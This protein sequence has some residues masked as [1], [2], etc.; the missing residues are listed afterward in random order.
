M[1]L[2]RV[3]LIGC[4]AVGASGLYAQFPGMPRFP[5]GGDSR[6]RRQRQQRQDDVAPPGVPVPADSP[7][8]EAFRRLE[9]QSVYHQRMTF[10]TNDP[11]IT[12]MMAQM[13]FTPAET[14]TAGDTKQV[15][16]HF[17][18]PALGQVEDFELRGVLRNGRLAKKWISPG[19]GRI[20]KEQDAQIA[21][22]LAEQEV[23]SAS[24][25]ARNLAMG[26]MGWAGAGL[27][28]RVGVSDARAGVGM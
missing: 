23:Q 26:P 25:I 7:I 12:Q 9:Q 6:S 16:M 4:L 14:I 27:P 18:M 15:S 28:V 5:G 11:Q 1:R 8:F 19:S 2:S 24:S 22:Q 17:K 21:R 13:G 10:L 20:L 3:L